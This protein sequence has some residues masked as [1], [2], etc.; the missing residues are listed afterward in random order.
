LKQ[1]GAEG[2]VLG[3]TELPLIINQSDSKIPIFDILHI[4]IAAIVDF[5]IY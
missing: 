2:I 5:A 4:H 3:C 1:I